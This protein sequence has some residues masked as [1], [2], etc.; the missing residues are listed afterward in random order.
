MASFTDNPQAL[1][2]FNP[3]I[4][5]LPV[6]AMVKVGMEKQQKY[7]EG[8]QKIQSNIDNVAGLDVMR[9]VDR[10]YL[11]SQL[12]Q[13]GGKLKTVAAGDF[14]NYQLVNSVGGMVN[15]ISKDPIIQ[16][17]VGSTMRLRKGFSDM[18]SAQKEGKSSPSN[19]WIYNKGVNDYLNNQDVK[20]SFNGKF[21]Q[22]ID[23]DKP[24]LEELKSAHA[25]KL[26]E[27]ENVLSYDSKG[28]PIIN[29]DLLQHKI[30]EGLSS[31]KVTSIARDVYNRPDVQRQLQIDGLY[32]YK[33][34]NAE[35][36]ISDKARAL[37]Y[38]KEQIFQQS[39]Y[40]RTYS[41]LSGGDKQIQANKDLQS[42]YNSL[43]NLDDEFNSFKDLASKNLDG[44]KISAYFDNKLQNAVKNY[45][46]SDSSY[47]TKVNP[48]FTV[49]M[50]K[51][52]FNL[53]K[54]DYSEKVRMDNEAIKNIQSEISDR[55]FNHWIAQQKLDGKLDGNGV[56]IYTS[57][58]PGID[59]EEN[60]KLGSQSAYDKLNQKVN[61]RNQLFANIVHGIGVDLN[62]KHYSDL[63]TQNNNG[64][65]TINP[66]YVNTELGK[67]LQNAATKQM[68]AKINA[69][70]EMHLNG[71]VDKAY[72]ED[73][74]KWWDDGTVI[75]ATQ[76]S[77]KQIESKYTPV[78]NEIQKNANLKDNY[79]F[80]VSLPTNNGGVDNRN[81]NVTKQQLTDMALY[82]KGESFFGKDSDI[83]KQALSRLKGTYGDNIYPILDQLQGPGQ[84]ASNDLLKVYKELGKSGTKEAL[85]Q[86]EA[87][88][89]NTQRQSVGQTLT[90]NPTD[91]KLKEQLRTSL[92]SE[93]ENIMRNKSGGSYA[94]AASMLEK[95]KGEDLTLENNLYKFRY[96]D[97]SGKW[98]AHISTLNNGKYNEDAPEIEISKSLVNNL[99]LNKQLS[100]KE[101]Y[102]NNSTIGQI[103]NLNQG[104]STTEDL[105]SPKAYATSLER[106]NIGNYSVGF[107]VVSKDQSNSQYMAYMYIKDKGT[108]KIY[109][110]ILMDWSKLSKLSGLSDSQK[111]GLI[112]KGSVYDRENIVPAIEEFKNNLSNPKYSNEAMKLLISNYDNQ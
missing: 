41:S 87:D 48:Q 112:N 12:N 58:T 20:T 8:I 18:E 29:H 49:D 52:K 33:D 107:Q 28:N 36:L 57:N 16:N 67:Q 19:E 96:D 85:Q 79:Q 42:N 59:S 9:D 5:Q 69:A 37:N 22:A 50:E 6:D 1:G 51:N 40:L 27:D 17:A 31:S 77:L 95:V 81:I 63:Y 7:D 88:M 2:T 3:Y 39:P 25:D 26:A 72:A 83:A 76:S 104:A 98:Y 47:E 73:I 60:S 105:N 34:Y 11:Q 91:P 14:S 46:W 101:S 70:G 45:A 30:Q 35:A 102:F 78:L 53:S 74:K 64:E 44:A 56:P 82:L 32:N 94:S 55:D 23:V 109:P 43:R 90:F 10:Q 68:S 21:E 61:D 89:A 111:Q 110:K 66:K 92:S 65:Y 108:G 80:N 97:S 4:Q 71:D 99:Q 103:L 93:L 54:A 106:G 13:L 24:L 15:Q 100:P 38:K 84:T 86:R 62:G 75:D